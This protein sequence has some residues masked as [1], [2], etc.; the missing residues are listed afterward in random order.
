MKRTLTLDED[1]IRSAVLFWARSK[2]PRREPIPGET[3]R[4][5]AGPRY[6]VADRPA[7]YEVSVIVETPS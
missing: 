6:T 5:M 3:V 2:C 1:D 7:G 4:I